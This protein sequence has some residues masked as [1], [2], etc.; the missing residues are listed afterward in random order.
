[1]KTIL[2]TGGCGF[3]GSHFISMLDD[4]LYNVI[5]VDNLSNSNRQVID[6]LKKITSI[7]IEFQEVDL[8][9]IESIKHIFRS[10]TIDHVVHFAGLKSVAESL[11]YPLRYYHNNVVATL[12]LLTCMKAYNVNNI[13][14]SSSATVYGHQDQ[15]PINEDH[16]KH[17]INPYGRT[18]LAVEMMLHDAHSSSGMGVVILRYF[19]PVGA[20]PSGFIGESPRGQPNNL[21]P[22]LLN[23]AARK[24]KYLN[25]FGDDYN[26]PDGTC[27]RDYIHVMDLASAHI[28]AIKQ[29]KLNEVTCLNVGT[30]KPTSVMQLLRTFEEVN[31]IKIPYKIVKR[32]EGDLAVC[33][34]NAH[35]AYDRLRWKSNLTIEDACRDAWRAYKNLKVN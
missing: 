17:P 16:P 20:H 24:A 1:M 8:L 14:F 5:V 12:H 31:K 21:M 13:I 26:T 34:A 7:E 22:I 4:S 2:V 18:K 6:N 28:D 11:L 29:L 15:Q 9:D 25:I 35:L 32:R 30:G 3:I 33:Y 10:R 19:N 23:V 27:L